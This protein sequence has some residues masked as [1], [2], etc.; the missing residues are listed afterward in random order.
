MKFTAEQLNAEGIRQ[1]SSIENQ[2]IDCP[3]LL[4]NG[5]SLN[6]SSRLLYRN[7][8]EKYIKNCPK[9]VEKLF[10]EFKSTNFEIILEHLESTERVCSALEIEQQRITRKN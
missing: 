4:G 2:F 6:F 8:Y 5:F 10:K 1:W 3:L 7:L 9:D